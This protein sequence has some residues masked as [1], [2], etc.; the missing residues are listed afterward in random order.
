MNGVD[1]LDMQ[2]V[3]LYVP[4]GRHFLVNEN[5]IHDGHG[6]GEEQTYGTTKRTTVSKR[7]RYMIYEMIYFST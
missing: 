2:Y 4:M 6:Y 5:L 1:Y 3:C 7:R